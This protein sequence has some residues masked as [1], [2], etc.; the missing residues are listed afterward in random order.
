M[1]KDLDEKEEEGTVEANL[2]I[3]KEPTLP[4]EEVNFA[5]DQL[6]CDDLDDEDHRIADVHGQV[7]EGDM[8]VSTPTEGD[9]LVNL[10]A[11]IQQGGEREE[12]EVGIVVSSETIGV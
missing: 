12:G 10:E 4:A 8:V 7:E 5:Y 2:V 1:F 6:V 3:K 9:D 11:D